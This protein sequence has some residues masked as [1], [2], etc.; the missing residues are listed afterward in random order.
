MKEAIIALFKEGKSVSVP[1]RG[2]TFPNAYAQINNMEDMTSVPSR[3]A[4][5]PNHMDEIIKILTM[6]PSPLGE[7]HFLIWQH[8]AL[9]VNAICFRPLSGSY[10]S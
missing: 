5:F 9:F 2:A 6:F 1:S 3:G 4:T 10:I 7:L 8:T